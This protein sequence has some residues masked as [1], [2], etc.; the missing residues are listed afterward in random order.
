MFCKT[1]PWNL[2]HSVFS[3]KQLSRWS[4][5]IQPYLS[6]TH[7]HTNPH[8]HTLPHL[9]C[10]IPFAYTSE[11]PYSW[12]I[13]FHPSSH[14]SEPLRMLSGFVF[15]WVWIILVNEWERGAEGYG[16]GF[17]W[18]AADS[19]VG[20]SADTSKLRQHLEQT[21]GET[22]LT[23]LTW[24][25]SVHGSARTVPKRRGNRSVINPSSSFPQATFVRMMPTKCIH[26]WHQHL[27]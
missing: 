1:G 9:H 16:A 12:Q 21:W 5:R 13:S 2:P 4:F 20:N 17:L 10:S 23:F 22:N 3:E 11:H 14:F 19:L 27:L 24:I 25:A 26:V 8:A 18:R 15:S 6:C 7:T